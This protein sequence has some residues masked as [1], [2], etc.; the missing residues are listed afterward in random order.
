MPRVQLVSKVVITLPQWLADAIK[1]NRLPKKLP[2]VEEQMAFAIWLSRRNAEERTGGPFGTVIVETATGLVKGVGVN[3]VVPLCN[4]VQHGEMVA[5]Q[6]VEAALNSF[7]LGAEGMPGHTLVTSAQPCAMCV[8]AIPWSGVEQVVTGASG[9]NVE[10]YTGFDEGPIHPWW[11]A[12]LRK[13]GIRVVTGVLRRDACAVL[14]WYRQTGGVIYNGR[15]SRA[16]S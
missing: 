12:E 11:R 7:T 9:Y 13:R 16:S 15:P 14:R 5:I 8:G 3:L 1:R 6:M 10:T 2:T 4:S